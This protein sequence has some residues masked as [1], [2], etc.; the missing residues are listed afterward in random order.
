MINSALL[1]NILKKRKDRLPALL[2]AFRLLGRLSEADDDKIDEN[3]NTVLQKVN[4]LLFLQSQVN[5]SA[6]YVLT[7][8]DYKALGVFQ[9]HISKLRREPR[10]AP[11]LRILLK[12]M[13]KLHKI[14][15]E[16][17]FSFSELKEYFEK[18]YKVKVGRTYF[19]KIFKRVNS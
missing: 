9:K 7:A 15:A 17:G 2:E 6:G 12:A 4:N 13:P 11:K 18:K 10:P 14:K 19:V 8:T 5:R 16:K 1:E 3:I